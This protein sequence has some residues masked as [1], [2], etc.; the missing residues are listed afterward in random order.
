M[1]QQVCMG[2]TLMCSFGAAPAQ[3]TVLPQNRVNSEKMIAATIMDH[4]P[5]VNI[6]PFGLCSAPANPAVIAATAAKLGVFTPVPCI[7]ATVSPWTP[8][9]LT[10]KIGQQPALI[11]SCQLMCMWGGIIAVSYPGQMTVMAS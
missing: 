2:A 9:S 10:V 8:G 6:M 4:V 1:A 3:L 5:M 7:P 11:N